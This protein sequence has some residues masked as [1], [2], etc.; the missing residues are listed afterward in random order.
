MISLLQIAQ[1]LLW[2]SPRYRHKQL[3]LYVPESLLEQRIEFRTP[4]VLYVSPHNPGAAAAAAEFR[5]TFPGVAVTTSLPAANISRVARRQTLINA[6]RVATSRTDRESSVSGRG[7]ELVVSADLAPPSAEPP[8]C[9]KQAVGSGEPNLTSPQPAFQRESFRR[10]TSRARS[11]RTTGTSDQQAWAPAQAAGGAPIGETSG[12][13]PAE[14]P[15]NPIPARD[16]GPPPTHFFLYLNQQTY[17]E[18]AGESLVRELKAA[19]AAGLRIA[20]MHE[21]DDARQGCEFGTFFGTTPQELIDDGLYRALAIAFV[22]GE[23]H[24][25]VSHALFAKELGGEVREHRGVVSRQFTSRLPIL[26]ST[27]RTSSKDSN[28]VEWF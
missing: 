2:H 14:R 26:K 15:D 21:N 18:A 25:Q 8:Y 17:L 4:V 10:N 1:D 22:S 23:A 28:A 11:S 5:K 9:L 12:A 27:S 20:M 7:T 6:F 19:R 24:R 16:N 3:T 13:A